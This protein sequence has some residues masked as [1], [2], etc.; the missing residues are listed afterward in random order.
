MYSAKLKA[1]AQPVRLFI[2]RE[3]DDEPSSEEDHQKAKKTP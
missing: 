2:G 3:E 1:H